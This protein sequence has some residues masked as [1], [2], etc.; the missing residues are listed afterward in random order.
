MK[1]P[2]AT[3]T[4]TRSVIFAARFALSATDTS[5]VMEFSGQ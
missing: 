3:V 1:F 2:Q 5:A 4:G